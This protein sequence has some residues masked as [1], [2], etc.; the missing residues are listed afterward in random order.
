[1]DG[2]K[3]KDW[4]VYGDNFLFPIDLSLLSMGN[5]SYLEKSRI[6]KDLFKGK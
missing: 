2:E 1:M 5:E 4:I 6:N 3:K